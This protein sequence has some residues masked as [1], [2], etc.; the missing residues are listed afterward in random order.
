MVRAQIRPYDEVLYYDDYSSDDTAGR[1]ESAGCRVIRGV[2]N[3]GAA[4]GRNRLLAT[5]N[6]DFVHFHDIDDRLE[7]AFV[8]TLLPRAGPNR[9]SFCA[10]RRT[11]MDGRADKED[12]FRDFPA[13]GPRVA[14]FLDHF[15]TFNAVIYPKKALQ[16]LGGFAEWLRIHEDLH[17]LLRLG[18]TDLQF[19][20]E[21]VI[22]TTWQQR[23]DST[24]VSADSQ[25]IEAGQLDCIS[26]LASRWPR[27]T[28]R[29]L[30]PMLLDLA[31][32]FHVR[33]DFDRASKA[34][35]LARV[36]GQWTISNRGDR[37][38]F[39]SA[40]LGPVGTYRLI[41]H[42]APWPYSP[43]APLSPPT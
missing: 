10:Y 36:C 42:L 25:T 31:W 3:R 17:L 1:L 13:T 41:R 11:S 21:D 35:A 22:L 23:R 7:A 26:D 39:I 29:E 6:A 28:R 24:F 5:T 30:G 20:Y 9:A 27:T 8:A 43:P 18:A 4:Y 40:V 38:Q 32:S 16:E 37:L 34:A 19:S 2:Q 33:R 14:Y 15:L 12:R